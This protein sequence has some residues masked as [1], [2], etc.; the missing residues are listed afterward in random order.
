LAKALRSV[1]RWETPDETPRGQTI[2]LVEDND[3]D[4]ELTVMAF[5]RAKLVNPLIRSAD[6]PTR[7]QAGTIVSAPAKEE[8][9]AVILR[10]S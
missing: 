5:D 2:L 1:S 8:S 10:G 4:A 9:E 3:D 6:S 7:S